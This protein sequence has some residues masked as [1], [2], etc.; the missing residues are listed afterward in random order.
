MHEKNKYRHIPWNR[1]NLEK[2]RDINFWSY[3]PALT[4]ITMTP[5]MLVGLLG[6]D[7]RQCEIFSQLTKYLKTQTT[8][9]LKTLTYIYKNLKI[10]R[11]YKMN[12]DKKTDSTNLS[13]YSME[14]NSSLLCIFSGRPKVWL[15]SNLDSSKV[16]TGGSSVNQCWKKKTRTHTY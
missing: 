1:Y 14:G 16:K 13:M 5:L 8:I 3:R 15:N 12:K 2:Y 10:S 7:S 6:N 4:T 9:I 11:K